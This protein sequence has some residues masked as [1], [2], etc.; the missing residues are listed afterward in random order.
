M[1]PATTIDIQDGQDIIQFNLSE[2][3]IG[4]YQNIQNMSLTLSID[5]DQSSLNLE[6]LRNNTSTS[7]ENTGNTQIIGLKFQKIGDHLRALET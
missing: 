3:D 5:S 6:T 7:I 4:T 1:I 2:V